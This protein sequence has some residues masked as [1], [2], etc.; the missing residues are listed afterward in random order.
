MGALIK[1]VLA[2][3]VAVATSS[4]ATETAE[5]EMEGTPGMKTQPYTLWQLIEAL[6]NL[7][8]LTLDAVRQILPVEFTEL[9]RNTYFSPW[10]SEPFRLMDQVEIKTVDLRIRHEDGI[11]R[12]SVLY[13]ATSDACVTHEQVLAHFPQVEGSRQL[14]PPRI[15]AEGFLIPGGSYYPLRQSWGELSF[16]F[17]DGDPDCLRSITFDRTPDNTTQTDH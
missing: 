3:L 7:P 13:L 16:I 1:G 14:I 6:L 2:G 5:L 8:V 10:K 11:S 12:F 17:E 4:C 15:T 9:P